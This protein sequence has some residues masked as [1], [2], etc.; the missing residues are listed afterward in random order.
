MQLAFKIEDIRLLK[1]DYSTM[2]PVVDKSQKEGEENSI[3]VN[4]RGT[5]HYHQEDKRLEIGINVN[6]KDNS[7]GYNLEVE[8]G[9]FFDL[10][11]NFEKEDIER[12]SKVNGPAILFPYVREYVSDL[13][14]RAGHEPVYLP[15]INFIKSV[16]NE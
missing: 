15:A 7:S 13:T 1:A 5:N 9:A 16:E 10:K 6:L 3:E 2:P 4:M 8:Y 11:G 14:R 12:I